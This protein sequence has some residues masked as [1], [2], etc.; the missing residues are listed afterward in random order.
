ML[1]LCIVFASFSYGSLTISFKI[2]QK[3]Q[4]DQSWTLART[5]SKYGIRLESQFLL[6]HSWGAE[7]LATLIEKAGHKCVRV[8]VLVMHAPLQEGNPMKSMSWRMWACCDPMVSQCN[9]PRPLHHCTLSV[10]VAHIDGVLQRDIEST[11][12]RLQMEVVHLRCYGN[13]NY[14][15]VQTYKINLLFNVFP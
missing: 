4:M 10:Q 14:L 11:E 3:F 12:V 2:S 15:W 1:L 7:Q 9:A 8:W 13:S 6:G 5:N